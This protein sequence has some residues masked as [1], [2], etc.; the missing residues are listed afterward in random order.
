MITQLTSP[1]DIPDSDFLSPERDVVL[2]S[3]PQNVLKIINSEARYVTIKKNI[4]EK[5][6]INH[7]ELSPDDGRNIL[8]NAL[9]NPNLIGQSQPQ[10]KP[11]YWLAVE[12]GTR[13]STVVIDVYPTK[14]FIE[15]VGWRYIESRGMKK[16]KRQAEREGGQIL[17]LSPE[18]GS[19][20]ALSALPLALSGDKGTANLPNNQILEQKS[21]KKYEK[22][23]PSAALRAVNALVEARASAPVAQHR[24]WQ[25]LS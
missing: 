4:F 21:E 6:K 20:A 23:V 22:A 15:V 9:Y 13:N 5:N 18:N 14:D 24:R 7:K 2:P 25:G 11:Y 3:L 10:S 12:M 17:I 1:Q 19:A 16:L 8:T